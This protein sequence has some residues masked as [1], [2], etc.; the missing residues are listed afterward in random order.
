MLSQVYFGTKSIN[1]I[2]ELISWVGF[3]EAWDFFESSVFVLLVRSKLLNPGKI[4][5]NLFVVVAE[6]NSGNGTRFVILLTLLFSLDKTDLLVAE[7]SLA[8]WVGQDLIIVGRVSKEAW[9]LTN[10]SME[11]KIFSDFSMMLIEAVNGLNEA[12]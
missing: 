1:L 6:E 4:R 2:E 7:F 5:I 9:S 3:V 12:S 11:L 8:S 10:D